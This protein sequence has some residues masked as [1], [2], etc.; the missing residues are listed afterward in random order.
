MEDDI[1]FSEQEL[2]PREQERR[3]AENE[4]RKNDKD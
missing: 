1:F 3:L 2:D 4:L